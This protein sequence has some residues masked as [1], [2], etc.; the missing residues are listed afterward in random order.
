MIRACFHL[1]WR[2]VSR[3][4]W[5][6]SLLAGALGLV[7]A[8]PLSVRVIVLSAQTAMDARA[9]STPQVIGARGSALDL[10]L[11]SLYFK[12]QPLPAITVRTLDEVRGMKLGMAIPVYTR[13]HAQEAP[14]VGTQ[15]D[16]FRLRKLG[17]A[18]GR[19]IGRLGDCVI[20]AKLAGKRHLEPGGSIFSSQEQVFD[21][22]GVYPLKM[23]IT[24]ILSSNG[25]ADDD[26]VFVDLK[27][28]WLIEGIA[29]GHD[30]LVSVGKEAV[31]KQEEGNVVGNASVRMYN[32]V[33]EKNLASFHFHGDA[34]S[35]PLS[36]ILMFP[37]DAKA[38]AILAGRYSTSDHSVQLIRPLDEFKTLMATLFQ[39]ETLVFAIL[40]LLT[41]SALGIAVL[42]FALSFRLRLREFNTLDDLGISRK[43]LF[44][45][46]FL[47]IALVTIIGGLVATSLIMLVWLNADFIVSLML[48]L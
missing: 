48:R 11:T 19:M 44:L 9:A 23:R 45:T 2:Y 27:T 42:V 30:D 17:I 4:G 43:A 6:T 33:S 22:A 10:L 31:L 41:V 15:F 32:E 47:E 24:G 46:K 3:H 13:F 5:Q 26:A 38:E 34:S 25:T 7:L 37:Q 12:H 40:A 18:Q 1:A 16:Y 36:A 21:L 28:T 20:G 14:I 35:Y 29:H 8:L 39:I